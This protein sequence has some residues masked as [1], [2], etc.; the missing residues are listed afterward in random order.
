MNKLTNE[1]LAKLEQDAMSVL[2]RAYKS[3]EYILIKPEDVIDMVMEIKEL[4]NLIDPQALTAAY[5]YGKSEKQES[6]NAI[7]TQNNTTLPD[8]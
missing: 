3:Q 5:M 1:K 4:R 7:N 8:M 6:K 2:L